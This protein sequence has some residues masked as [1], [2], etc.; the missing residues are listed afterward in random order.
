MSTLFVNGSPNKNGNTARLASALLDDTPYET[1]DL[2]ELKVYPYG[3]K[4]D[5]DQFDEVVSAIRAT[6]DI[7]V[8]SPMY[9]H[10]ICGAVRNVLD[11]S[12]GT[13]PEGSLAGKRLWFVFQG[14]A[15]ARDQL[16]AADFTMHR[17]ADLYGMEYMG[18]VTNAT[19]AAHARK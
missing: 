18:M 6:D 1:I 17:Y 16:A 3:S 15:P 7:V 12:Y 14:A 11:R 4:F 8:G 2:T 9:W 19:E 13:I 10:N 5:D